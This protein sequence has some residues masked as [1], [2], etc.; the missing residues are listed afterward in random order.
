MAALSVTMQAR[1]T[2]LTVGASCIRQLS[3]FLAVGA[4]AA[5]VTFAVA[6]QGSPREQA[7]AGPALGLV[8]QHRVHDYASDFIY[9]PGRP[10]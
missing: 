8:Q 3:P 4:V 1:R 6:I 2:A 5:L 10:F 9:F 7:T